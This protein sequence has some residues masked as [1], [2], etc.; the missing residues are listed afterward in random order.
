MNPPPPPQPRTALVTSSSYLSLLNLNRPCR[1]NSPGVA[2]SE[3]L[4]PPRTTPVS[5]HVLE[6]GYRNQAMNGVR[7]SHPRWRTLKS[8]HQTVADPTPIGLIPTVAPTQSF[9]SLT[10]PYHSRKSVMDDRNDLKSHCP[11]ATVTSDHSPGGSPATIQRSRSS[12]LDPTRT[13]GSNM[14]L[15][16]DPSPGG[17]FIKPPAAANA[18]S[19]PPSPTP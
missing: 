13:S 12:P 2:R 5:S 8:V 7:S 3:Q 6:P 14:K 19:G 18:D 4:R 16:E 9:N 17:R 11:T 15:R 10:I 1:N